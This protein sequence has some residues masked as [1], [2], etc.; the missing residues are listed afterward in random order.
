LP[1]PDQPPAPSDWQSANVNT[2][3]V[4]SGGVEDA[5]SGENNSSLRYPDTARSSVRVSGEQWKTNT[6]PGAG[7]GRQGKEGRDDLPPGATTRESAR[8]K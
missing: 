6:E 2:V 5:V 3:D 1:L 7:V 4:G 8:F